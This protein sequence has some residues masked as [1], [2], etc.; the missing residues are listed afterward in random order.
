MPSCRPCFWFGFSIPDRWPPSLWAP[1][2]PAAQPPVPA[3]AAISARLTLHRRHRRE[4]RRCRRPGRWTEGLQ[5]GFRN[6]DGGFRTPDEMDEAVRKAVEQALAGHNHVLLQAMEA[7][8][9]RLEGLPAMPCWTKSPGA[10][11]AGF[12]SWPMPASCARARR[13][14]ERALCPRACWCWSRDRNSLQVP[15]SQRCALLVPGPRA[16]RPAFHRPARPLGIL[17][18]MPPASTGRSNGSGLRNRFSHRFNFGQWLRWESALEEMRLY[19]AVPR[20]FRD[21][22]TGDVP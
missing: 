1:T 9:I 21:H 20:D 18:A 13:P 16:R 2:R 11:P 17:P 4:G 12:R 7:L 15:L 10:S 22:V 3:A 14:A 6:E 5:V 8:Q 19:Y